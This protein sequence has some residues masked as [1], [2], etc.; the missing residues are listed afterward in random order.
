MQ[1]LQ[2]WNN[3]WSLENISVQVEDEKEPNYKPI[4]IQRIFQNILIFTSSQQQIHPQWNYTLAHVYN[5]YLG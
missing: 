3:T 4:C 2:A 1:S 5:V